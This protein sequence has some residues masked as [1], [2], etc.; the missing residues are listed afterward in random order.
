MLIISDAI[1][2]SGFFTFQDQKDSIEDGGVLTGPWIWTYV[3]E[4]TVDECKFALRQTLD[5][6]SP[7][8]SSRSGSHHEQ[9]DDD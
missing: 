1:Q 7:L 5:T 2:L 6:I 8:Y 9:S 3:R 4:P